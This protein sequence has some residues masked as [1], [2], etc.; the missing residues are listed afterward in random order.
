MLAELWSSKPFFHTLETAV[1]EYYAE[2]QVRSNPHLRK[3]GQN[4]ISMKWYCLK[5]RNMAAESDHDMEIEDDMMKLYAGVLMIILR[6]AR[7]LESQMSRL[8]K[9]KRGYLGEIS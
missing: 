1:V 3:A 2:I 7:R 6:Y 9:V 4:H 8:S 5:G